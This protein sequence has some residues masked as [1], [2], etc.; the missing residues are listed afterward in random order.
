[1]SSPAKRVPTGFTLIELLIVV[2]IIALLA[3]ILF[4]V[5]SRA[6]ENARRTNCA[7]NLKQQ[8]LGALQYAQDFDET[9]PCDEPSPRHQYN[10]PDMNPIPANPACA[11]PS[12]N[13]V[14]WAWPD[15][16]FPYVKNAQ[17]FNDPAHNN[18]YFPGCTMPSSSACPAHTGIPG[19]PMKPSIYRGPDQLCW[20]TDQYGNSHDSGSRAGIGYAYLFPVGMGT[21]KPGIRLSLVEYPAQKGLIVDAWS[22]S[23]ASMLYFVPRHLDGV[24]VAFVDGHVN[25]LPWQRLENRISPAP[26]TEAGKRF[27]FLNGVDK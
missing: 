7:S 3:A 9:L 12:T 16:I 8:V 26:T 1:M 15:L 13:C 11:I 23:A 21:P 18:E 24:N 14:V 17:I 4:P 27:W 19:V 6:R 10:Y 25:W 22:R 20:Y 2:A 5:L